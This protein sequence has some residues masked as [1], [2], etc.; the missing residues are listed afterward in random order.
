MIHT[1]T[2][3]QYLH[4]FFSIFFFFS[5]WHRAITQNT[6]NIVSTNI[7]LIDTNHILPAEIGSKLHYPGNADLNKGF[8][9]FTTEHMK[10]VSLSTFS[11]LSMSENPSSSGSESERT[12][13]ISVPVMG[14]SF[15]VTKSWKFCCWFPMEKK[16]A[17]GH[18]DGDDRSECASGGQAG[19]EEGA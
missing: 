11:T 2:I 14:P 6:K 5:D 9:K 3:P 1:S 16:W 10:S 18:N 17:C 4:P 12:S 15:V 8:R 13:A 7:I 19:Y